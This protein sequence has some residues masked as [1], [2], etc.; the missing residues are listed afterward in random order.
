[1]TGYYVLCCSSNGM[2]YRRAIRPFLCRQCDTHRSAL[3]YRR[4]VAVGLRYLIT[5]DWSRLFRFR[6][7]R[8]ET[9]FDCLRPSL[10]ANERPCSPLPQAGW[11]VLNYPCDD[12]R[13]NNIYIPFDSNLSATLA[14]RGHSQANVHAAACTDS[15]KPIDLQW[16]V[17]HLAHGK[18]EEFQPDSHT[19]AII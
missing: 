19:V 6:G 18:W 13:I 12:L 14:I 1:M 3:W 5:D 10:E 11:F 8:T 7:S 16:D 17:P 4:F 9:G 2:T 15:R